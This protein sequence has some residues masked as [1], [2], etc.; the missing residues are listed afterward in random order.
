LTPPKRKWP[1]PWITGISIAVVAGL[2]L[3]GVLHDA[4]LTH[5]LL[6]AD[7]EAGP[8]P[9]VVD[10]NAE[11]ALDVVDNEYRISAKIGNPATPAL[12]HAYLART[13]YAFTAEA[14]VIE[15]P[16]GGVGIGCVPESH[17]ALDG[18]FL[19]AV[20]DGNGI[21]L[22]AE[23]GEGFDDGEPMT[24]ESGQ[25][26]GIHCASEFAAMNGTVQGL[27]DGKVVLERSNGD[28]AG[29]DKL[30]LMF[31]PGHESDSAV[32]DDVIANVP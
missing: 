9:F 16:D 20:V 6:D 3:V 2:V 29:F 23:T 27:I 17:S 12:S 24:L 5:D 30:V 21:L 22:D 8:D 15:V 10:E 14:T 31:V 13:A 28:S 18:G 11:Y 7:F 32:F 26:I 25:R 4:V 1:W 19:F